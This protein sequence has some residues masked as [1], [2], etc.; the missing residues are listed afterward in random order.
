MLILTFIVEDSL[1][2]TLEA[3]V[4]KMANVVS[5]MRRTNKPPDLFIFF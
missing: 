2:A 1:R 5:L 4:S 3:D